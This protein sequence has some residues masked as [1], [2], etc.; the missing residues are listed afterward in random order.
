MLQED[1]VIDGLDLDG[2]LTV[3][4]SVKDLVMQERNYIVM[5]ECE[6]TEDTIIRGY[7]TK[8]KENMVHH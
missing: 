2:S 3:S 1:V 5:E 7:L 4:Q 6:L 8:G